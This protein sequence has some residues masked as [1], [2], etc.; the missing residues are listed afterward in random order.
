MI[1][2]TPHHTAIP[3]GSTV[4][5]ICH[6]VVSLR[7]TTGYILWS[8]RDQN[9]DVC[10]DILQSTER[11]LIPASHQQINCPWAGTICRSDLLFV[12][13]RSFVPAGHQNVAGG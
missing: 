11:R 12:R 3:L 7:T 8:H 5:M 13:Q 6:P 1:A 9:H 4:Q 2:A 10:C